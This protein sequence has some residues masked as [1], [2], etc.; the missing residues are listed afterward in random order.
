MKVVQECA[1]LSLGRACRKQREAGAV[2]AEGRK[3]QE[4]RV[5]AGEEAQGGSNLG[6]RGDSEGTTSC[7]SPFL[8]F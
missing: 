1:I 5:A 6:S 3:L 4:A 8:A 7:I 2:A